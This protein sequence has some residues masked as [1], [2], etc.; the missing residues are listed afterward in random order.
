MKRHIRFLFL[1]LAA[2]GLS[3][4]SL[5]AQTLPRRRALLIGIDD[6]SASALPRPLRARPEQR[7]WPDLKGSVNDAGILREMLV[8]VYGFAPKDIVTLTNQQATRA[9]ILQSIEQHLVK[10][11]AKGD[12]VFYYFAG[13]GSQVPNPRSDEPDRLD[14]SIVPADSRLGAPDIRDKELRPLFNRILDRG[15]HLTLLLDHCHSG[16]GFRG[17]PTGARA[18][19]IRRAHEI[20]DPAPYG[21]K[22]DARGALVLV[23]TQDLDAAWETRGDDG[24]LH[25]SFTWAWIRAVR[26]S[27]AGES[28]QETFLRAQARL[29]SETPYQAPAILGTPAARLR[30]FLGLRIDRQADRP[31]VGVERVDPDGNVVLQGGWANGLSVGTELS[32]VSDRTLPARLRVTAILG[33][34]R[35]IARIEAGRGVPQAVRAGALLEVTGWAAP[36]GRPLRVWAPRVSG[37]VQKIARLAQRIAAAG[38][39]RWLPDPLESAPTH[40][41]RPRADRWELLDDDGNATRLDNEPSVLAAVARL[42]PGAS[43]FVQFPVPSALIDGIAIGPGTG[44]EGI[45]PVDDPT[46]ADYILAGRYYGHRMEYAWVRPLVRAAER[47]DSGLPQRTAWVAEDGRDGTLRDSV[48][49]L[50]ESVLKLR[51]IH[52]WNLLESPPNTR[53]PYRLALFREKTQEL[54]RDGAVIGGDTYSVVL[55]AAQP[56]PQTVAPRYYYAFIIDSHGKSYLAFPETGSVENRFPIREPAPPEIHLGQPSAFD[57]TEP[58]GVDTYFLLST[59]EPLPNLA[60]LTWDGVRVPQW[61]QPLNPLE[62]LLCLTTTGT[63]AARTLTTNRWSIERVAFESVSPRKR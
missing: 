37:D 51:R 56:L 12:V 11:A 57:I 24:L 2:W 43:L 15:A 16:S 36:P 60:V 39:A 46:E 63:R 61:T 40:V 42:R 62:E 33:L 58:Y 53:A 13:H 49:L 17:L 18:R 3:A 47:R 19:G 9:A 14:E 45:V 23:S 41:L 44:R 28:A 27:V 38:K 6:Y 25:G 10:P 7:G 34:G 59:D 30:P 26:D 54:I 29:R 8:L 1:V 35:S 32:C 48:A 52:A 21:P 31:V 20:S 22:P 5:D 50:R 4:V 55:R